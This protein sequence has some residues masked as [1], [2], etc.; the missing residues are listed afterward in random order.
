MARTE[1]SEVTSATLSPRPLPRGGC[2][3]TTVAPLNLHLLAQTVFH[4]TQPVDHSS[5][6]VNTGG[7]TGSGAQ[8]A[9]WQQSVL[10]SPTLLPLLQFS[11][12]KVSGPP[13][14]PAPLPLSSQRAVLRLRALFS[15][16]PYVRFS[17]I[18]LFSPTLHF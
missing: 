17:K 6:K 7:P 11:P 10:L 8:D 12:D 2:G 3:I 9:Q 16:S 14:Q 13:S 18:I 1:Q 5:W 15:N 4:K